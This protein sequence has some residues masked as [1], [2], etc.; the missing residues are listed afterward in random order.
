MEFRHFRTGPGKICVVGGC[1]G[2]AVGGLLLLFGVRNPSFGLLGLITLI[3][4]WGLVGI[5]I[6]MNVAHQ[7]ERRIMEL[8]GRMIGAG[9]A[10]PSGRDPEAGAPSA[11]RDI[12]F[13]N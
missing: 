9:A 13:S 6:L 2:V 4:G 1:A 3:S 7:L 11:D 8:E 10:Q 5:G 12:K